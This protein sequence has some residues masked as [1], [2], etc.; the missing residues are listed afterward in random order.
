MVNLSFTSTVVYLV[1]LYIHHLTAHLL[2]EKGS[3]AVCHQNR[4]R[5]PL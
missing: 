2:L 4:G 5:I 1:K 3:L